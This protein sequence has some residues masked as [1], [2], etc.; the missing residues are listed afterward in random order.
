MDVLENYRFIFGSEHLWE[1]GL[2][3]QVLQIPF[4]E[5]DN[6]CSL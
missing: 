4:N 1:C 6:K 3:T 2:S 5:T